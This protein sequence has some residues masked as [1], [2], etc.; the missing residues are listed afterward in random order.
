MFRRF[1]REAP[2]GPRPSDQGAD[3]QQEKDVAREEN[4]RVGDG[5]QSGHG[6][7]AESN[8]DDGRD[9]SAAAELASEEDLLDALDH[10]PARAE[11]NPASTQED[12][13]ESMGQSPD[14]STVTD[15]ALLPPGQTLPMEALPKLAGGYCKGRGRRLVRPE[16]RETHASFTSEQRILILDTWLRSGLP[17]KDFAGL[18]GISKHTLYAWKKRFTEHGPAGL[19]DQVQGAPRG[20]RVG[21][22]TRRAIVMLKQAHPEWG[23]QRIS[24]MLARGPALGASAAAVSRVLHEAGY[25]KVE[26]PTRAHRDKVRRFERAKPNQLWQTDLFTFMLKRQNRRVHLVAF[27]DDHSRFIVAFGLSASASTAMVLETL[28]AG[29]SHHGLPEEILTDNGSQYIT[30]RGLGHGL[31]QN[32]VPDR[33]GTSVRFHGT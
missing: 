17:A 15:D 21:E 11:A 31:Q 33:R 5:G 22:V 24:D 25:E 10:P 2:K 27:M 16:G 6:P 28:R 3:G 29:I 20:S 23:C 32:T 9:A 13:A 19:M 26:E 30:W 1:I 18:I 7:P 14:D 12:L 8:G 4:A